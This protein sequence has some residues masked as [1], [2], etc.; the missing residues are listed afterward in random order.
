MAFHPFFKKLL[1]Q[2]ISFIW[3]P[4]PKK[5]DELIDW[6]LLCSKR[7]SECWHYYYY[8]IINHIIN[9]AT[10]SQSL[11]RI[12]LSVMGDQRDKAS[13]LLCFSVNPTSTIYCII[14]FDLSVWFEVNKIYLL[15]YLL[16]SVWTSSQS[17]SKLEIILVGLH[18]MRAKAF[19][20]SNLSS[21]FVGNM[22]IPLRRMLYNFSH[23]WNLWERH[24]L[25]LSLTS[26]TDN[27]KNNGDARYLYYI[28]I[29]KSHKQTLNWIQ[30][31]LNTLFW[32]SRLAPCS[33][34]KWTMATLPCLAAQ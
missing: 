33:F 15:T 20:N 12:N 16:F 4:K 14:N 7:D 23:C 17:L 5:C 34:K 32:V 19:G 21:Q 26:S 9:N 13:V 25:V 30:N 31:Q 29:N 18:L 27:Y 22:L 6:S 2:F 11:V 24:F 3:H 10:K 8:F 28:K 1:D